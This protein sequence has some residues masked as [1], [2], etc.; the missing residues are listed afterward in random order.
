MHIYVY[1]HTTLQGQFKQSIAFNRVCTG[2]AFCKPFTGLPKAWIVRC[3]Q[4]THTYSMNTKHARKLCYLLGHCACV[5]TGAYMQCFT[6]LLL[7]LTSNASPLHPTIFL[8]TDTCNTA[9][10]TVHSHAHVLLQHFSVFITDYTLVIA[11]CAVHLCTDYYTSLCLHAIAVHA[12]STALAIIRR[13]SPKLQED[14][15]GAHP[16]LISPLA[17]TAQA[18]RVD[19]PGTEASHAFAAIL[20]HTY[21]ECVD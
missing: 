16:Y 15:T 19:A 8:P 18:L 14:V 4:L 3:V 2:Q 5:A 12:H 9:M 10:C 11:F 6:S 17:A 13:L 1:M 7:Q 21:F 20:T